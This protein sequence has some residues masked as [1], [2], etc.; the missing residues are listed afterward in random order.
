MAVNLSFIGGAGWQFFDDNGVPLAG[1]K[2]YSYAAG[3]TTPQTTYTSYTGVTPNTNPIILDA[4]GRTPQQIWSTEG[5]LYKYAVYTA[6]N[7]LIRTW[8]NIGGSVVASDLA[9]QLASTSISSEGDALIGFRQS[10]LSGFLT[11]AVGK[12]VNDKLQEF[13]S[14]KD[15]GAVGNGLADD[16]PAIQA[17]FNY[18]LSL[19][20]DTYSGGSGGITIY[21]P[22]GFYNVTDLTLAPA[23]GLISTSIVGEGRSSE[24]I[25]KGIGGTCLTIKNNNLFRISGLVIINTSTGTNTGIKLQTTTPGSSST[26]ALL[27]NVQILG[28]AENLVI[29]SV[30]DN[31][32]S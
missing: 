19:Q 21:F 4:A 17:A 25:Y 6:N 16:T 14:V 10:N 13:V 24:L 27:Q 2:I 28:F 7:V 8:D 3:T 12:T 11:G 9:Q 23:S 22:R 18:A 20:A 31:A 26:N 5:I 30:T 29:G 32:A 1:G 15:F